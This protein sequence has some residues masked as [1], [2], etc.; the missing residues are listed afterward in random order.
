MV[1][2][3]WESVILHRKFGEE[4]TAVFLKLGKI[5]ETRGV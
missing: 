2:K 5:E 4:F 1:L 3:E